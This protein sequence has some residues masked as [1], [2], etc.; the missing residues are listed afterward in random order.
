MTHTDNLSAWSFSRYN[1]YQR[2]PAFFKYKHIDKLPVPDHPAMARGKEIHEKAAGFLQGT[3]NE[4]PEELSWFD[5]MMIELRGM[6]PIVE[7]QWG[8]DRKWQPTGWFANDTWLR[9]V[10][11]AGVVYDDNTGVVVDHKTGKKYGDNQEQMEL[12]AL[13][14]MQRYPQTREVETRLWYLDSGD[15]EIAEFTADQKRELREKWEKR[16]A[17]MMGDKTFAARPNSFC[18]IC[19]FSASNSGPCQFG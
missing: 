2:C 14:F 3:L 18:K 5:D 17:P 7:Q 13:A 16:I 11:D 8:F 1:D 15:E 12:F 9:V 19:P 4:L 10:L 6:D